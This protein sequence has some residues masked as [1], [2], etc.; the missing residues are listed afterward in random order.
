MFP[1]TEHWLG[2]FLPFSSVDIFE[3]RSACTW[4][5]PAALAGSRDGKQIAVCILHINFWAVKD[6]AF[7]GLLPLSCLMSVFVTGDLGTQD[8]SL[9]LERLE[10]K[11]SHTGS[12]T[13]PS[14]IPGH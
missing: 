1:L 14:K 13:S 12:Q 3:W 8:I 5:I 10:N 2:V 11:V 4:V 6:L 7:P 9:T